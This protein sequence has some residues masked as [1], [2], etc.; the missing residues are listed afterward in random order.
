VGTG[1]ATVAAV[2]AVPSPARACSCHVPTV[3]ESLGRGHVVAIVTRT[4]I[5]PGQAALTVEDSIGGDLPA[6]LPSSFDGEHS[7]QEVVRHGAVAAVAA[8]RRDGTWHLG[9]CRR[10]DLAEALQYLHGRPE[11]AAGGPAVA[12]A[13]GSY[14]GSRL[15]ALDRAGRV[16]GWGGGDGT[17][18]HVA[19]CPDGRRVVA[20]GRPGSPLEPGLT[21]LTVH[22]VP[23]LRVLRTVRLEEDEPSHW[24]VRAMRCADPDAGRVEI[25]AQTEGSRFVTVE[26]VRVEVAGLTAVDAAAATADGFVVTGGGPRQQLARLR[27]DGELERLAELPGLSATEHVAVAPDG[28]TA[29]VAGYGERLEPEA[30]RTVDLRTGRTLGSWA[31]PELYVTGLVW[32]APDRLLARRW[33]G[34]PAPIRVFDR[35]L[36][37]V[38]RLRAAPGYALAAVGDAAVTYGD[39][40]M[41]VT[42]AAGRRLVLD[43]L[44]LARTEHVTALPGRGFGGKDEEPLEDPPGLLYLGITLSASTLAGAAAAA[45]FAIRRRRQD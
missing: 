36:T 35:G 31:E 9:D 12:V 33:G 25:V 41:T 43:E 29:A 4:D 45:G 20:V 7:C 39:T 34:R 14:G 22:E 40:R 19:A 13:A 2:L 15:A 26:G 23:T 27:P 5:G 28:R 24:A 21:E 30:L 32:I 11:P 8:E 10:L 37:E 42:P 17:A 3:T 44:R 38:D 16:V 1:L 6:R 18:S